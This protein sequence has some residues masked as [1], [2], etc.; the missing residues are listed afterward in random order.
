MPRAFAAACWLF[1]LL[2]ACARTPALPELAPDDVVLAF[3]DSLTYGTGAGRDEAYP[4]RLA[5]LI[6]RPVVNAGVPGETTEAGLARLAGAL[7]AE[8]PRLLLLCLGGNDMLRHQPAEA[9]A[10]NLRAM[11]RLARERG[12][13]VLLIGV[14][15]P[16]LLGGP[17]A[18]YAE[19]A[20]EFDL[21]YEG[22]AFASVLHDRA[23][24]SD[25]IHANAAGYR[26]VA[27]RL[28]DLL[29]K[30]GAVRG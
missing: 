28:A 8:N 20:K 11:V 18:Y 10:A 6:G 5:A 19:I 26:Q 14:P 24:K 4:A 16:S 25:L 15:Q 17:P 21:P 2:A 27:E 29:R 7:D 30:A 13:A 12:V 9:T 1:L 3:G 23:L 22:E